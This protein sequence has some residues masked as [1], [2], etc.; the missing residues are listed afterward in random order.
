MDKINLGPALDAG[1]H[2]KP[3]RGD[4]VEA[5]IR[6][7]KFVEPSGAISEPGEKIIGETFRIM[8]MC[9]N[10]AMAENNDTGLVI[11]YVQ[12]GKTLSFTSLTAL[13][14]D[15]DYQLV[16]VIAGTST[17]LSNQSFDR[18][19]KDL[20]YDDR[21]DRKWMVKKNAS[22][23]D[24]RSTVRLKL[25]QWADATMPREDCT[26]ILLTVMKHGTRLKSLTNMLKPLNLA[27]VPTLIIDDESDQASMNTRA[28]ANASEGRAVNEGEASVIYRRINELRS[29]FPHHTFLQYTA[30]PQ[31]NLF[32]NIMDRLS[33]NFIKLLTP[34]AGYTGGKAFF[35][36]NPNLIRTIPGVEIPSSQNVLSEPPPSLIYALKIFFLG[37]AAGSIL[38]GEDNRSMMVHPS[39]LTD[40]HTLYLSWIRNVQN[41]WIRL[42][43][44]TDGD[45]KQ[46]FRDSF[47]KAY[48]DLSATYVNLPAFDDLMGNRLLHGIKLTKIKELN[49]RAG[50]TESVEWRDFYA[51]ILVGG[52]AMDRGFTVE[53]LTITYMPRGLGTGQVDTTL[54][55][56]RFF[57]YKGKYIG[58]CRVWLDQQ[59][60]DAYQEIVR[61]EEDVRERLLDFD[62]NNKNLNSWDRQ[63]VLDQMLNLTRP[64][65]IYNTL[66]RDYLGDDWLIIKAPHD[67]FR[68][69]PEN[70]AIVDEFLQENVDKLA[71]DPG[72]PLRTD[73]QKHLL[74][75]IP[76]KACMQEILSKLK[77]TLESDSQPYSS[78]RALINRHLTDFPDELCSVFV[79]TSKLEHGKVVQQPRTRRLDS[80][81]KELQQLFQGKNSRTGYP[82]DRD[83]KTSGRL[84]VQIHRLHI[85]TSGGDEIT[86]DDGQ[87]VGNVITLAIWIP[88]SI[89]QDIIRQDDNTA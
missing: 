51:H 42:L 30:T 26:T 45:E 3:F 68:L 80:K 64:N 78:V 49:S 63:V 47:R 82:G 65:V 48:D 75:T 27:G 37:V 59:T 55:R 70:R 53:G 7:K 22:T 58:Y 61:H 4:E 62:V 89:G 56:A 43:E 83:I 11:G 23:P 29:I 25:E 18:V 39:R 84:S 15:N 79:M 76:L 52:Q 41:S 28:S 19:K 21:S 72:D 85:T 86:D 16:I 10:P 69:I 9:G 35:I 12:S 44:S 34:G 87:A 88:A 17:I 2:W 5:I 46:Q 71:L 60:I 31:A 66:Y 32:I 73:D 24:D 14:N 81:D 38:K 36:E 33:P 74:A 1:K 67:T 77:F 54:Q 20:R 13:A 8:E 6:Y 40:T 57:G 50:K